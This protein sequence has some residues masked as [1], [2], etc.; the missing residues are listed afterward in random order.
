MVCFLGGGTDHQNPT[1]HY[2]IRKTPQFFGADFENICK[3]IFVDGT[4]PARVGMLKDGVGGLSGFG[5]AGD[6]S[7]ERGRV[8][9]WWQRNFLT[10]HGLKVIM[11]AGT[12]LRFQP[13]ES[14]INT[15]KNIAQSSKQSS[16]RA[17]LAFDACLTVFE[18][19][20]A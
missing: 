7:P 19:H 10:G 3:Y 8:L 11:P 6:P 18:W 9:F 2:D 14:V 1:S 17:F 4:P 12:P 15:M 5:T 16:S 20:Q 13:R